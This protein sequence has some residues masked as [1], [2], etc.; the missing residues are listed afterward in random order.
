MLTALHCFSTVAR[1]SRRSFKFEPFRDISLSLSVP[2]ERSHTD[3][4][5]SREHPSPKRRRVE[6]PGPRAMTSSL[7]DVSSLLL[8]DDEDGHEAADTDHALDIK[9]VPDLSLIHI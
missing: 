7:E 4:V 5:K 3:D 8:D 6:S 1:Y 2:Q 9:D